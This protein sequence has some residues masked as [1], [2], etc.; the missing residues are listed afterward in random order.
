MED[1]GTF[2]YEE[3]QSSF[4]IDCPARYHGS[5]TR[6]AWTTLYLNLQGQLVVTE[7]RS[8]VKLFFGETL[9]EDLPETLIYR[10][11]DAVA[12][13]AAMEEVADAWK[14]IYTKNGRFRKRFWSQRVMQPNEVLDAVGA[15]MLKREAAERNG[16]EVIS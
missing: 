5:L 14:H 11:N 8:A 2:S 16:I 3:R 9:G 7:V 12:A 4:F 6:V 13:T 1:L 15:R 10:G